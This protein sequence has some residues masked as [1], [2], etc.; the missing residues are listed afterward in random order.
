MTLIINDMLLTTLTINEPMTNVFEPVH[1][2]L[3]ERFR[4]ITM[5]S[6]YPLLADELNSITSPDLVIE[7][8]YFDLPIESTEE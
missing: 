7:E 2:L 6:S 5:P 4:S 1:S 3:P 8:E